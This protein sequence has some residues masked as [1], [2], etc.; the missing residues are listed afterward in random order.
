MRPNPRWP[1]S[2]RA[3]SSLRS[4]PRPRWPRSSACRRPYPRAMPRQLLANYTPNLPPTFERTHLTG[5]LLRL[6]G[7]AAEDPA[8]ELAEARLLGVCHALHRIVYCLLLLYRALHGGIRWAILS[9]AAAWSLPR[10]APARPRRPR[11]RGPSPPLS[12]FH[13]PFLPARGASRRAPTRLARRADVGR[14]AGGRPGGRGA[15]GAGARARRRPATALVRTG[16]GAGGGRGRRRGA[17][18]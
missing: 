10:P 3:S 2:A 5:S 8:D 6:L 14:G 7:A 9:G 11:G 4:T 18:G 1:P 16:A 12:S 17:R 13:L 15:R